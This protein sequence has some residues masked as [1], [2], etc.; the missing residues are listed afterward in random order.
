[1][2]DSITALG[3]ELRGLIE[4][5]HRKYA[6]LSDAIAAVRLSLRQLQ[7][8]IARAKGKPFPV[9]VDGVTITTAGDPRLES[10]AAATS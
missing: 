10:I 4:N 5:L 6:S 2:D 3:L 8:T 9:S 7:G 1:V